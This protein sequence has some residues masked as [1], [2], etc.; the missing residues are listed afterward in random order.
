MLSG[1]AL[2]AGLPTVL[3]ADPPARA[4]AVRAVLP[5]S[6][7][8]AVAA[9]IDHHLAEG[10]R[11]AGVE[12]APRADDSEFLRRIYLDLAGRV[13]SVAE[14]CRFLADKRADKRQRVIG[15][16]LDGPRYPTHFGRVWRS[17]WLPEA[18]V[19]IQGLLLK[20]GFEG[21]LRKHLAAN[22][23]YDKVVRELLTTPVSGG[24][25]QQA[26]EESLTGKPTPVG[27]YLA[28]EAKPENLAAGTSR[29]FLGVKLE[30]AQC[31]N[32]PFGDWK[33]EQFWGLAAFFAGIDGKVEN[34]ITNIKPEKFERRSI[35]IPNTEKALQ[36]GFATIKVP[37]TI[38]AT[39]LD[40]SRPKWKE[41][42]ISPRVTLAE[43][44][45]AADNPYFA[46][47]AVNRI[48]SYF[49]GNGL[50]DPVDEMVGSEIKNHHPELL[51]ELSRQFAASGFDLKF[52]MRAIV[53]SRAYQLTSAGKPASNEVGQFARMPLRGLTAEQL[54]DS[55]AQ[56]TGY[57]EP[58]SALPISFV[59]GSKPSLREDFMTR[60]ANSSEKS[61]EFHT[62]ILHALALMNGKLVAQATDLQNSET[63]AAVAN[64]PFL[65]TAERI[66]VLYLAT[67]SRRPRPEE[68]DRMRG[69]I[70][71]VSAG[72]S[73]A[74]ATERYNR[75][76]ADVFWVLLNSGEFILNH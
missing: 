61:T 41:G 9:R 51:D 44:V 65:D 40:G 39:F 36:L 27:F 28:K 42:K 45:T 66:E 8:Q 10:W 12:P 14:A 48:W 73:G 57:N 23:P 22:T 32:H 6:D 16:L 70:E 60:F 7:A 52:L 20:P 56:A 59:P 34:E 76:L 35:N 38:E 17:L 5:N 30:C 11:S 31:H 15:D 47:A 67:L 25:P 49:F 3:R 18:A 63:L 71:R 68:R 53:S 33:R 37:A 43:W 74:A 4:A 21:W 1:L 75:G 55:V 46:R 54:Y 26:I 58:A 29:L 64:A 62:S 50:V 19:G 72:H 24:R 69:H 13:P 2:L